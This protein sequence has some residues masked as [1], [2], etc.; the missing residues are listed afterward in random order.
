MQSWYL[1]GTGVLL[2]EALLALALPLASRELQQG[3]DLQA[4]PWG[5]SGNINSR[6]S[7]LLDACIFQ[8]CHAQQHPTRSQGVPRRWWAGNIIYLATCSRE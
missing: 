2:K 6:G 4:L 3:E 1:W 8:P 5:W 7:A